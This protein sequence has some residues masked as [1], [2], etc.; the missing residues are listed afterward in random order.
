M[1]RLNLFQRQALGRDLLQKVYNHL[2]LLEAEYFGL[3]FTDEYNINVSIFS[4]NIINFCRL[5]NIFH[6]HN[7]TKVVLAILDVLAE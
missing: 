6:H 2:D 7:V 4:L 5:A 3:Q 1:C